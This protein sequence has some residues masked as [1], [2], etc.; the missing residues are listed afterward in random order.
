VVVPVNVLFPVRSQVP[1]P[2]FWRFVT[3]AAEAVLSGMVE[4]ISLSSVDDPPRTKVF[5]FA[6]V[7][8]I[9]PVTMKGDGSKP[10]WLALR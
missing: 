10:A 9:V 3:L 1:A 7:A 4:R 8:V 2:I 6:P 5:T